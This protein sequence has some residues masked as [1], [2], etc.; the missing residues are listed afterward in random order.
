MSTNAPTV[1][2]PPP[3]LLLTAGLAQ[4][5]TPK[6]IPVGRPRRA[7]A[8]ALATGSV[9]LAVAA[10]DTFH[11]DKTTPN[12]VEPAKATSL[13]TR[14][15]NRFTRNP[16]YVGMAG[17]LSAQAIWRGSWQAWLPVGAFGAVIDRVQ[18]QAEE[19]A[20]TELFGPAYQDY[21]ARTPRWVGPESFTGSA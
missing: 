18:I 19:R 4:R 13:V 5:L 14:G 3:V 8:I 11:S 17:L 9:A 10:L 1:P 16:M 12:P 15:P 20:L 21:C 7:A 2:V 6:R